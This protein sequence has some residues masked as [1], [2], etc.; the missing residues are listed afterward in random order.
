MKNECTHEWWREDTLCGCWQ[1]GEWRCWLGLRKRRSFPIR[2]GRM[3]DSSNRITNEEIR[4]SKYE[5]FFLMLNTEQ[6]KSSIIQQQTCQEVSR[7]LKKTWKI[8]IGIYTMQSL[9]SQRNKILQN[10]GTKTHQSDDLLLSGLWENPCS[11][12][13][14]LRNLS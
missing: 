2:H 3:H 5:L 7:I 9:E 10:I 13:K 14:S 12:P 8:L 6:M 1:E 11:R 4:V